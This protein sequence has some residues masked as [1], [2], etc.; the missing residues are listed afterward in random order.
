MSRQLANPDHYLVKWQQSNNKTEE[1]LAALLDVTVGYVYHLQAGRRIPS[2]T[3]A[4]KIQEVTGA[5][6]ETILADPV[7]SKK[8]E[9]KRKGGRRG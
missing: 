5:K 6:L 4:L 9:K 8:S 3:V 2:S 7:A 1:D